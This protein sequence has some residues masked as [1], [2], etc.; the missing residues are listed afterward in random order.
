M[1]NIIITFLISLLFLLA[2]CG[3][4]QL[5]SACIEHTTTLYDLNLN[6]AQSNVPDVLVYDTTVLDVTTLQFTELEDVDYDRVNNWI[7]GTRK[8]ALATTVIDSMPLEGYPYVA[9]YKQVAV[10]YSERV[11]CD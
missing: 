4:E 8:Y 6:V 11:F 2:S 10:L 5:F 7:S 3:K 9:T 1:K